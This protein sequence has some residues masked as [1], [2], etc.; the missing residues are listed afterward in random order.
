M[1]RTRRQRHRGAARSDGGR[2]GHPRGPGLRPGAPAV[3]R[4]RRPPS[5]G[6]R[7]VQQHGRRR[8]RG[9]VRAGRG[10]GDRRPVRRTQHVGAKRGR[11]RPGGR[12]ERDAGG[13]C[14]PGAEAGPRRRRGAP[15]RPRRRHAGARTRGA[16]RDGRP[17]RDRWPHPRRRHGLADPAGRPGHRQPRVGRD[18]RRRRPGPARLGSRRTRSCSGRSAAAAGTSGSSPSSSTG[19]T[20]SARWS[21]SRS[22]SGRSERG[23]EALRAI[24]EA[25]AKL[26]RSCNV[27]LG[28]LDRPARTVRPGRTPVQDRIRADDQRLRQPG[29]AR[30]GRRPASCRRCLR[31]ST[32]SRPMPYT[33]LQQLFDQAN[34][35]GQYYY[36]KSTRYAELT[37]EVIEVMI[38]HLSR[39]QLADER[40]A[41]LPPGRGLLRGRPGRDRLRRHPG[42][43][44]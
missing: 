9:P 36:E 41:L 35:W 32:P 19:C 12:P 20:R 13:H 30:R 40:H 5:G 17:H 26:P 38:A 23:A 42:D 2:R 25:V 7:P 21:S 24:R 10:A 28:A 15:L 29:R 43:P 1:T 4:R 11:R 22:S 18:R 37:D 44:Q 8:R 14:R 3:E 16:H 39:R 34:C 33:A 31:C 6:G 27:I